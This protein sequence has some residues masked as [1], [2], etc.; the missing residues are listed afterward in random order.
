MQVLGWEPSS[1][2]SSEEAERI[3]LLF[4]SIQIWRG[5]INQSVSLCPPSTE[6]GCTQR[7]PLRLGVSGS[8]P[9]EV[10]EA[11]GG[12]GHTVL[13]QAGLAES[14]EILPAV[15]RQQKAPTQLPTKTPRAVSWDTAGTASTGCALGHTAGRESFSPEQSSRHL[16]NDP[17]TAEVLA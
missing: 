2:V 3:L 6:R 11:E 9:A 10:P 17:F 4:L 16:G 1:K 12:L 8:F 14:Q 15:E 7:S 5:K 13:T